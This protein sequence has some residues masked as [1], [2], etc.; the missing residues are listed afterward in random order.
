[1]GV[2]IDESRHDDPA[3]GVDFDGVAR[4]SEVLDTAGRADL[5]QK[6][7]AHEDGAIVNHTEVCESGPESRRGGPVQGQE[8]TCSAY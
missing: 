4:L 5:D 2:A 8:T 7:V 3:S 6:A 1:M